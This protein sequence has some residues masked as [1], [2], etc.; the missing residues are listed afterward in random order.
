MKC[1][2]CEE[3]L[4]HKIPFLKET[5]W[6][7]HYHREI[8]ER[9]VSGVVTDNVTVT[10]TVPVVPV[11]IV[12][13]VINSIEEL[14]IKTEDNQVAYVT[15]SDTESE[16]NDT[17]VSVTDSV[18]FTE[19]ESNRII[20]SNLEKYKTGENA[21][22]LWSINVDTYDYMHVMSFNLE[23]G[24]VFLKRGDINLDVSDNKLLDVHYVNK[25]EWKNDSEHIYLIVRNGFI[26]KIGGT[27][28][29][30][31]G[32]W[33][34][35]L[36]GFCVPQRKNKKGVNYPGK[37]SVTNAHIVHTIENDLLINNS[38]WE[39]YSW[40]IPKHDISVDI[41][42][43]KVN[44]K[45]QTFHAYETVCINKFKQLTQRVPILCKNS[46]SRYGKI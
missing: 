9:Y 39:I 1:P 6:K 23:C 2:R 30:L 26:M 4:K 22:N 24:N 44:I 13:T 37:M 29:G 42:G 35:Y 45:T 34:S 18:S 36:C 17:V 43:N 31:H 15:E 8:S 3:V 12:E 5:D 46:D 38:K 33:I 40:L 27:R 28:S 21:R 10:E 14:S 41:L 19:S 7:K 20:F 25:N 16:S 32:R 11:N